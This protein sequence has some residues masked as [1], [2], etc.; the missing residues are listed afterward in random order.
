MWTGGIKVEYPYTSSVTKPT[1]SPLLGDGNPTP[2]MSFIYPF[3]LYLENILL[4]K[5]SRGELSHP[6]YLKIS[7]HI[8]L[9]NSDGCSICRSEL[10]AIDKGL[11]D[12]LLILSLN[13]I[14]ILSD[15]RSAIEHL[16]NWHKKGDNTG[17]AILEKLN[18][19]NSS[20][21]IHL[22]WVPSHVNIAGN[23]TANSLAKDGAAQHTINSATLIYSE[24]HFTYINNKQS[25]VPPAHH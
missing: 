18:Y 12:A 13:S 8:K 25:T 21:E 9:R 15:N 23:E 11:K 19:L 1:E 3:N 16:S 10:I 20:R 6:E 17:V 5:W 4:Q 14:W 22:Q 2:D 7:N 24:L